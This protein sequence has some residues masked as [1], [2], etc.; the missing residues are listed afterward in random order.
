M[1][2]EP[3]VWS[4][5]DVITAPKMNKLENAVAAASNGGCVLYVT[6][7]EQT[8]ALSATG[9]EIINVVTAGGYVV[10]KITDMGMT[11]LLPLAVYGSQGGNVVGF[12]FYVPI[13]SNP[14]S[15][16][17]NALSEYP[18]AEDSFTPSGL[19]PAPNPGDQGGLFE[20]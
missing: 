16:L 17:C 6:E 15:Y 5:G 10:L 8:G 13:N 20:S 4:G 2:Y 7:N 12:M 1:S 18:V 19:E 3:T 14:V 11:T 9:Q